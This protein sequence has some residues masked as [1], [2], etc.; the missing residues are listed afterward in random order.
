MYV[1]KCIKCGAEFETKNPKRVICPNCLYADK[2]S[3]AEEKPMQS[4]SSFQL[5]PEN[6]VIMTDHSKTDIAITI[7]KADTKGVITTDTAE[8][9]TADTIVI[10]DNKAV[11][12][13]VTTTI[14]AEDS[15]NVVRA[16]SEIIMQAEDGI[17]ADSSKGSLI[18]TNVRDRK[19]RTSHYS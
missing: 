6:N 12:K 4:Y 8:I 15:N 7:V 11:I 14:E 10:T 5:N 16:V 1:N 17:T 9:I 13:D 3:D 19:N 18:L 2:S